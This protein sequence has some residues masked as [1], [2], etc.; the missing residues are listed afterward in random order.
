MRWKWACRTHVGLFGYLWVSSVSK[1]N[2]K[3]FKLRKNFNNSDLGALGFIVDKIIDKS[4]ISAG[5]L[6]VG[7]ISTSRRWCVGT[8]YSVIDI[9]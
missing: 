3:Q 7:A 6:G 9:E 4:S 2:K 1:K 5:G 8:Y